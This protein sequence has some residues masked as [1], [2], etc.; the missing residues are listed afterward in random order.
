MQQQ[1]QLKTAGTGAVEAVTPV[2]KAEAKKAIA[3]ALK[4][5]EAE[6]AGR[7]DLTNEEKDAAKAEAKK[8]ADA[9]LAE[10]ANN[11]MQ[12]QH[13]KQ[14]QQ[15]KQQQMVLKIKVQQTLQQ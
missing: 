5:K 13:Q 4:A 11:Q 10:I 2:A 3:D 14:Q 7:D 12:Q 6:I 8:L 1:T 9:Q 15:L